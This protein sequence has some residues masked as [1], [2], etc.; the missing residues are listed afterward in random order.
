M[1]RRA[2][3]ARP[4]LNRMK[5]SSVLTSYFL[6]LSQNGNHLPISHSH[7]MPAHRSVI[8]DTDCRETHLRHCERF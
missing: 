6:A 5:R 1:E 7:V 3:P 8:Y 4:L 2:F